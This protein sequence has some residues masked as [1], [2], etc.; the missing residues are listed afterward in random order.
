MNSSIRDIDNVNMIY[1]SSTIPA[2]LHLLCQ[3]LLYIS[4]AN[5]AELRFIKKKQ[6]YIGDL[7]PAK[8]VK[9]N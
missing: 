9:T 7:L 1:V 3:A 5:L 2:M 6:I 8:L 4:Q